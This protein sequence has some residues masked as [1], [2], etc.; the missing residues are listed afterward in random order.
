MASATA[1]VSTVSSVKVLDGLNKGKSFVLI[2]NPSYTDP[3]ISPAMAPIIFVSYCLKPRPLRRGFAHRLD[4]FGSFTIN[5]DV[6]F[7]QGSPSE[8]PGVPHV[9]PAGQSKYRRTYNQDPCIHDEWVPTASR[10]SVN[11]VLD[12]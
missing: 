6:P 7:R 1:V 5:R 3:M 9:E 10:E 11:I 4:A 2:G 8:K 12:I